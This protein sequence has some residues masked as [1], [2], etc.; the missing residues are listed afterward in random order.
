M[1]IH[2]TVLTLKLQKQIYEKACP[3][4]DFYSSVKVI[5]GGQLPC[6]RGLQGHLLHTV[7]FLVLA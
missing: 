6:V 7:T 1:Q 3:M 5:T 2:V 4:Q